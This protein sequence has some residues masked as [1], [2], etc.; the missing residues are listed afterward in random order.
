V[1]TTLLETALKC[2]QKGWYVFP[3]KA[4]AKEPDLELVPHWSIDSS[5]D[6][7]KITEWWTKKPNANICIDLGR[8]NL[9]VLDFD[10]GGVPAIGLPESFTVTTGRG[11][12]YYANGT[13]KQGDMY[14]NG[15]HIGEVKSA[16]GY[17]VGPRSKHPDGPLYTPTN[18]PVVSL[19]EISNIVVRIT[20]KP[21][22]KTTTAK[23]EEKTLIP[24][25]QIHPAMVSYA[26]RLRETLGL[27]HEKIEDLLLDWVYENCEGPIDDRKVKAV[28]AS[29][30]KY[31]KGNT[32]ALLIPGASVAVVE[33]NE[34][35]GIIESVE[36][37]E[38]ADMPENCITGNVLSDVLNSYMKDFP[39]AYAWPALLTAA[40]ALVPI[41][42]HI[43]GNQTSLFTA[44][45]GASH[46]GKSTAIEHA[47]YNLGITNGS[48]HY[49]SPK[50]GSPEGFFKDQ[51]KKQPVGITS[52]VLWDIDEWSHF[53]KKAG[54][55]NSTFMSNL[56]TAFNKNQIR[57]IIAKGENVAV[58]M[59]LS[60]IGG[61]VTDD[62]QS[63]FGS[64]SVSGFYDR[65]LFGVYGV[66]K[67][68]YMPFEHQNSAQ[69]D[70]LFKATDP[71]V[72]DIDK[73]IYDYANHL[74]ASNSNLGRII[75]I[76]IRCASI[77]AS[78][79]GRSKIYAADLEQMKPFIEYQEQCRQI[80]VPLQGLNVDAKM[81]NAI[82]GWLKRH[83][84]NG[85]WVN[86]RALKKGI[87][88]VL[89]NFGTGAFNT[90]VKNLNIIRAVETRVQ[91]NEG[92]RP[93]HLIRLVKGQ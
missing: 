37:D 48:P 44:L 47:R 27:D 45:I 84:D 90:A 49:A 38:A 14:V 21:T 83:A 42:E 71:C 73:S 7:K 29:I 60:L 23:P 91:P 11:T 24:Q 75:E 35:E 65:F 46:S 52:Q 86:Q 5:T 88:T 80:V 59:A 76:A 1:N 12:H 16:G 57:L 62:V 41:N 30:C 36:E 68:F 6:A 40:G 70:L 53:F 17:V 55:E 32:T 43:I 82:R 67:E 79:D 66:K 13:F 19:G 51:M 28:A 31:E 69:A 54:I 2:V 61:I 20:Q 56:N 74:R 58:D 87:H 72:V 22:V 3:A 63:C 33:P 81:S 8:S 25:G 93:S 34:P 4:G 89:D 92:A 15:E 50:S 85:Q 26:G 64:E 18:K 10:K 9:T 39:R 77:I 78:F